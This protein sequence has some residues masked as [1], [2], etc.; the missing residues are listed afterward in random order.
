[1]EP[2][3]GQGGLSNPTCPSRCFEARWDLQALF[4]DHDPGSFQ[5]APTADPQ[6]VQYFTL[7]S[8]DPGLSASPVVYYTVCIEYDVVWKDPVTVASS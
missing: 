6:E 5:A 3:R 1:M 7:F 2:G 4:P 8:Q